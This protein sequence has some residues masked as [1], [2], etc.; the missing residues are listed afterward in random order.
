MAEKTEKVR[1]M[2]QLLQLLEASACSGICTMVVS[3]F[4][5]RGL[6]CNTCTTS[7]ASVFLVFVAIAMFT[8]ILSAMVES[9][10]GS[11]LHLGPRDYE[12]V[13]MISLEAMLALWS[14][15]VVIGLTFGSRAIWILYVLA[16]VFD[17]FYILYMAIT[18]WLLCFLYE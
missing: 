5:L 6:V 10:A 17:V 14:I 7:L 9:R 18:L 8:I 2:L 15:V 12:D 3:I 16:V 1:Q 13:S 11:Q 4:W